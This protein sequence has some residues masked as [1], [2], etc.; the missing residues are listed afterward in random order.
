M[1]L[2]YFNEI[3]KSENKEIKNLNK[4]FHETIKSLFYWQKSY[5]LLN[6]ITYLIQQFLI[7]LYLRKKEEEFINMRNIISLIIKL[8]YY[9]KM[10]MLMKL[11]KRNKRNKDNIRI[12]KDL[13]DMRIYM[14]DL[15]QSS[16]D[17]LREMMYLTIIITRDMIFLS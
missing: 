12:D 10:I 17:F 3:L 13:N 14:K 5:K 7:I 16:F 15:I 11:I 1:K 9:I 4:I 8:L 2:K 6:N